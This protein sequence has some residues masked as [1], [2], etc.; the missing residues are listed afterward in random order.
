[1]FIAPCDLLV[2]TMLP[3]LV[4]QGIVWEPAIVLSIATVACLG[5]GLAF[6]GRR[7]ATARLDCPR[8][9]C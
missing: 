8:E 6:K 9:G 7:L 4:E 5:I 2:M 1:M 3:M